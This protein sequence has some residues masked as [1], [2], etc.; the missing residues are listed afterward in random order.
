VYYHCPETLSDQSPIL[1]VHH[2]ASRAVE[3]YRAD[4]RDI[5]KERNLLLLTPHFD[6]EGFPDDQHYV[7]GNVVD[8][9]TRVNNPR[10]DW[11]FPLAD[12]IFETARELS[13]SAQSGFYHFGHSAGGQ[14]V[15]R[16]LT[17]MD[18]AKVIRAVAANP[19]WYTLPDFDIDFPY[20]LN[21]SPAG[22]EALP[23][24][25][26]AA[27]TILVGEEDTLRTENL[28]QTTKADAQGQH[29]FARA[30]NYFETAKAVAEHL[31]LPFN[32][33]FGTV[34]GVGHSNAGM[35]PAAARYLFD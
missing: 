9:E 28:R 24:L 8:R 13:G 32:W 15:H 21:N 29:R 30:G 26:A 14:F 33:R 6:N 4:W 22:E 18:G 27:L 3:R 25:F 20:G 23:S 2:G 31:G 16:Y 34:P 7:L 5:A 1:I 19:G 10:A 35:A 11:T 12:R 17:F